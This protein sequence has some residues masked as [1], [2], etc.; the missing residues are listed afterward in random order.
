MLEDLPHRKQV[1]PSAT[2]AVLGM[3][4]SQVFWDLSRSTGDV[5]DECRYFQD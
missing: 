5:P 4:K 2:S 1:P 3:C